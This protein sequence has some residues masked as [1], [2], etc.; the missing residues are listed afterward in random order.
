MNVLD[1]NE[2]ITWLTLLTV[3]S[4]PVNEIMQQTPNP[5]KTFKLI[6]FMMICNFC[7]SNFSIC[8]LISNVLTTNMKLVKFIKMLFTQPHDIPWGTICLPEAQDPSAEPDLD[9]QSVA[10]MHVPRIVLSLWV[11]H[12]ECCKEKQIKKLQQ[13]G[14]Y[15]VRW[16]VSLVQVR[17]PKRVRVSSA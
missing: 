16:Y 5:E 13:Q 4:Q 8:C 1:W 3:P 9:V 10:D 11:T 17:T 2:I 12:W 14:Q 7:K 15:Y 6:F